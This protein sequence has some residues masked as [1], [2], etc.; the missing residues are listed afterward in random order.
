M[1]RTALFAGSFDPVTVGHVDLV[2]RGAGLFD[3]VVVAV[4]NNPAKRYRFT[5]EER[6]ELVRQALADAGVAADV[7]P[8]EG[9]VVDAARRLGADV[10]LRGLRGVADLELELRNGHANR[11]LSGLETVF[12]PALPEHVHVSSTLVRE[13]ASHGGD[14]SRYVPRVVLDALRRRPT[15]G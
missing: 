1:G 13:I 12:L 4:G 9:L 10:M 15:A 2:T 6:V 7:L 8:F 3:R 11:E 14:V 5:L